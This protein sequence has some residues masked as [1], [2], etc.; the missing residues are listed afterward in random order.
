MEELRVEREIVVHAGMDR[1]FAALTD[2]ALFPTWG[3]QRIEG[4]LAV[5]ERPILDFGP[6]GKCAVYVVALEAPRYFAYR[7]VQGETDPAIILGDPLAVPNNTLVEFRLDKVEQGTRVR[8]T[9]TGMAPVGLVPKS[10]LDQMGKG[11]ELML[12]GLPRHFAS[13]GMAVADR[14]EN[15]IV[16]P[17]PR[18][19]VF[20]ALAEPTRWWAQQADGKMAP[21]EQVLLDFGQFGKVALLVE[22][23]RPPDRL[24]FRWVQGV[25]DL[26]L[27]KEDPRQHPSTLV[28]LTLDEV[29]GGTRVRQVESGFLALPGE[30]GPHFKRAYQGWGVILGLLAH[31]LE[32]PG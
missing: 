5:G 30:V 3:P 19:R 32:S 9:E 10:A 14:I 28:E 12:A 8:V 15:E 7:W 21:G 23:V 17:A 27:R 31:H 11:W 4:K 13:E 2:P 26:A 6:G 24:A 22:A 29:P 1:V 16:V 20:A 18:A 25:D